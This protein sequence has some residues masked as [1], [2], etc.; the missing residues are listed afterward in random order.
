MLELEAL[1]NLEHFCG[2]EQLYKNFLGLRYTEGVKYLADNGQYYWLIDA[3]ASHQFEPKVLKNQKLKKIQILFLHV[4]ESH[5]FIK[6]NK[7][8]KAILTC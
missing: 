7:G 6:P 5:E 1:K 4:G 8:N 2:S 3:I